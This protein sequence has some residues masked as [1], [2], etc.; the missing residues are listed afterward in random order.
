MTTYLHR[1]NYYLQ[2]RDV[3]IAEYQD[4]FVDVTSELQ[5]PRFICRLLTNENED[6][7]HSE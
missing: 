1:G 5:I 3:L 6:R 4:L 2:A 7:T